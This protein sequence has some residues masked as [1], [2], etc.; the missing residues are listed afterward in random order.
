MLEYFSCSWKA[1]IIA[2][3]AQYWKNNP[4][5][6]LSS[7][8]IELKIQLTSRVWNS[9]FN[10]NKNDFNEWMNKSINEKHYFMRATLIVDWQT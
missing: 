10:Y 1:T 7:S 2:T 6:L 8:L 5:Q 9:V 4:E 3:I